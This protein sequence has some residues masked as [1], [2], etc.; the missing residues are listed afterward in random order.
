MR[1]KYRYISHTIT[2]IDPFVTFKK[3]SRI[4]IYFANVCKRINSDVLD[5][6]H[7][8]VPQILNRFELREKNEKI[9][10]LQW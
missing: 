1:R 2:I 3:L 10:A 7:L 5:E 6:V 8:F 4:I 9:K